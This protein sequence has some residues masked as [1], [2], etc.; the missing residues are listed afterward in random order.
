[1]PWKEAVGRH[2]GLLGS[3]PCVPYVKELLRGET[4]LL[5]DLRDHLS[6]PPGSWFWI[7]L[8]AA[9][10]RQINE[11]EEAAFR[12]RIP[13]ALKLAKEI[14]NYRDVVLGAVLDRYARCKDR[15]RHGVLLQFAL[16]E[17]KSPQLSRNA[18]WSQVRLDTKQMVCGW[19]AQEDLEDFY[20]LCQDAG[21]VDERRL[22]FWLRYKEQ[23]AFSQIVLGGD[24]MWS[25]NLDHREFRERKK[26]R[27]ATLLNS[28]SGNNAIVMQ[29]GEWVLVE[30][31]QIGNACYPYLLEKVPFQIGQPR[32]SLT[33][34]K[35]RSA[36]VASSASR[37]VHRES[38]EADTFEP[39][40]R[41]RGIEPDE[42][43]VRSKA[44]DHVGASSGLGGK[45]RDVMSPAVVHAVERAGG[46]IVDH[47]KSGG[48]LWLTDLNTA[49][50]VH[51]EMLRL[52]FKYKPGKGL[53]WP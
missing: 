28:Q 35:N 15:S 40:L 26:G 46:R 18:M 17:W 8:R 49:G 5:D 25:S 12:G 6:V 20:R 23:I 14:P 43:V 30:F 50:T 9:L 31:S 29:I 22:K 10:L 51:E 7:E 44:T 13:F 11:G 33:E 32:Y 4:G 48:N 24:L 37:L 19:L 27:L 3:D 52:G 53:Y 39:F 38:W 47:R 1:M 16:E 42:H 45:P 21:Q 41:A 2:L 36:S 34:L